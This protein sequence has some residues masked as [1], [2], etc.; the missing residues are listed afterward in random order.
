[1]IRRPPR[2]TLFPYTTLFRSII[3]EGSETGDILRETQI[4][5]FYRYAKISQILE[6]GQ[7]CRYVGG[8]LIPLIMMTGYLGTWFPNHFQCSF[9]LINLLA[10][11]KKASKYLSL[12]QTSILTSLPSISNLVMTILASDI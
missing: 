11:I 4:S 12:S 8:I 10:L 7:F 5:Q 9:S 3:F 2:S 1:M 6:A